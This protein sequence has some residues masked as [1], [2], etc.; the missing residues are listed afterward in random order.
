M[1]V[2]LGMVLAI[3]ISILL[4]SLK[5]GLQARHH[6]LFL[7]PEEISTTRSINPLKILFTATG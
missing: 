3:P 5:L 4:S 1:P 7:I 6:G 2:A